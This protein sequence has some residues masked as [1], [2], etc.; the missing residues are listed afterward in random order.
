M[1]VKN[2]RT[3]VGKR[4]AKN[5]LDWRIYLHKEFVDFAEEAAMLASIYN[6]SFWGGGV[7]NY[8][9]TLSQEK[10][11][12]LSISIRIIPGNNYKYYVSFK[13]VWNP[14]NLSQNEYNKCIAETLDEALK[15]LHTYLLE[16]EY[17][18]D[19]NRE[20]IYVMGG[21]Y[22]RYPLALKWAY[23]EIEENSKDKILIGL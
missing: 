23:E 3:M 2:W 6:W 21:A 15:Y 20:R 13:K 4:R 5:E 14:N 9:V 1:E 19:A 8:A 7:N 17:T 22:E 16:N 18:P 11:D 12:G 10:R